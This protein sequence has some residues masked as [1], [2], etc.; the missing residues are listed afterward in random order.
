[1]KKKLKARAAATAAAEPATGPRRAVIQPTGT[2]SSSATTATPSV[3]RPMSSI[4]P[5]VTPTAASASTNPIKFLVV[6][7]DRNVRIV[8]LFSSNQMQCGQDHI[9]DL[10]ADEW[11]DDAAQSV[12]EQVIAQQPSRAHRSV[13]HAA[14]RQ[15]DERDD[16]QRV[17]DDRRQD[18]ALVRSQAQEVQR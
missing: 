4:T 9:D 7:Q 14:Q 5:V 10:D 17:E 18:G 16:D 11:R 3:S 6:N 12:D 1:M 8:V 2:S 13:G 15:R